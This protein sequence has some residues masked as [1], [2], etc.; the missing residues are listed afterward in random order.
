MNIQE[1]YKRTALAS[2]NASL[3]SLVPPFMFILYGI[4]VAPNRNFVFLI[5]PFL[6]YSLIC[7]HY[8]LLNDQRSKEVLTM[9]NKSNVD[10]LFN[11]DQ[12]VITFLPAPSLRMLMFDSNGKLAGE[13]KDF[14][15]RSFRWFL[16][17]FLDNAFKKKYGLFN[18]SNQLI[19]SFII[20]RNQIIIMDIKGTPI[21]II[22]YEHSKSNSSYIF[23]AEGKKV[24]V[25]YSS[26]FTDYQ[27][28]INELSIGRLRKGWMPVEWGNHF[29]DP[30]SPILTFGHQLSAE[31]KILMFAILTKLLR[32]SNH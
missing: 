5:I 2:L 27:F 21:S 22:H 8:Y 24:Q 31:E 19:G 23:A 29:K 13:I 16:P 17:Y 6:I 10:L 32:C 25:K 1:F 20:K 3:A 28:F 18:E 9:Q 14:Q 26:F 12:M 4:I 30:N 15:F 11:M 7:Y